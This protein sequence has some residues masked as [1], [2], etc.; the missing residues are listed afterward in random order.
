M[1]SRP[2]TLAPPRV[3]ISSASC[4]PSAAGF[5]PT[6]RWSSSAWR[7]SPSMWLPSLEAEP[8]TPKPDLDPGIP[9]GAHGRDARGQP[10]VGAGAVR[11]AAAGAGEEGDLRLVQV[12]AVGV[13]DVGA[14]P[15]ERLDVVHRAGA[16]LLQ[17]ERVLVQR[18]GQVGV[19]AD[20]V[21]AGQLG[22]LAHQVAGDAERRARRQR[23]VH[24]A[25]ALPPVI[26]LDGAVAVASG[27]T[28]RPPRTLSGG[29]PPC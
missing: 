22:A 28:P 26:L 21:G 7:A 9:H 18:L 23:H 16:E 29:R 8:S 4:A 20:A 24:H 3:A 11:H 2:S 10:H 25:E 1:S 12:D 13:P 6:M 27:W 17:A 14:G 19:Q 5:G 15:A